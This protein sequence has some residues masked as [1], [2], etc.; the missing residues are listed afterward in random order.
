MSQVIKEMTGVLGITL[1]HATTKHPQ[2]IGLLERSHASIK[3]AL[4]VEKGERRSL[5]HKYINIAVLNYNTS[6]HTSIG[7]EPSR[8]FH[9]RIPYNVLDL[10]LEINPQQQPI[11]T[12][13]IAPEVLEQTEMIHQMF[14]R[15]SCKRTL[16][17]KPIMTKRPTLQNSKKQIKCTSCNR[18]RIIKAAKFHSQNFDGLARTLSK[19]CYQITIIWYEKLALTKRKCFIG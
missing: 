2:T 3:Q 18:K 13:Q 15:I 11:L 7:C 4:K 1:K 14:A 9:G 16:N 6:Y 19:K 17:T 5:W 8:V 10:K 12:S